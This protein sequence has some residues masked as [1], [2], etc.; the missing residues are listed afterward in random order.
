MRLAQDGKLNLDEDVGVYL[1]SW[2]VPPTGSFQPRITFRQLLT[3]S[4][5][6]SVHGFPGYGTDE[7]LP[8]VVQV[9]DGAPPANTDPVRVNMLPGV[10]FRY[11]G[12]GTTV[13]QL[14]VTELLGRPFPALM[15][16]L[17]LDPIGMADSTYEQPLP[18]TLAAPGRH[19]SPVEGPATAG[20]LA[21]LPG[22][23]RRGAVDHA[24]GPGPSRNRGPE[25]PQR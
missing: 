21:R 11:S 18:P 9:L 4:A 13:A 7:P 25:G 3:H 1:K 23:G 5:G 15:R 2:N 17:I 24:V 20:P 8:T 19:G 6:L 14:A 12:G 22:D 10:Q 16:E